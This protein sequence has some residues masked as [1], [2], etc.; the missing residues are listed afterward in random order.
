VAY[1]RR[2]GNVFVP[3]PEAVGPWGPQTVSGMVI[4]GLVGHAAE[5]AA[6]DAEF[7]GTRLT[8]DMIRMAAMDELV[9]TTRMLR[10]GR[11]LRMVDVEIEQNGKRVAHGRATF[12]RRSPA[13]A[14]AV[15]SQ[16]GTMPTPPPDDSWPGSGGLAYTSVDG[17][18]HRDFDVWRNASQPKFVWFRLPVDL[19]DDE[20]ITSFVRAACVADVANPLT[21]WGTDG[22][23]YVNSD[24][25]FQISRL[26][27]GSA[28]GLM[29]RDRQAEAG[30]SVGTATMHDRR[31][32]IG[33][34]S[35][36]ALSSE[37]PMQ[38]PGAT[39][40]GA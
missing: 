31:G 33:V 13:P 34:C 14:G 3:T 40:R 26:P 15:W 28:V 7:L 25:T 37:V 8:V 1:L 36:T 21:N 17:P 29:A 12:A 39:G 16:P 18:P 20:P 10:Q 24:V 2:A 32:Q 4:A 35:V 6:G 38:P 30:V 22:L 23:E 27:E 5:Q 9:A 19:V 11:R